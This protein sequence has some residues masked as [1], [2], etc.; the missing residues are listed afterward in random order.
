[1]NTNSHA[2]EIVY[3]GFGQDKPP[4]VINEESGLEI[5]LVRAAFATQNTEV[6]IRLFPRKML[7]QQVKKRLDGASALTQKENDGLFYSVPYLVFFNVLVTKVD[8]KITANHVADLAGLHVSGWQGASHL[9]GSELQSLIH[10]SQGALAD[11]HEVNAQ[12]QQI[13]MLLTNRTDALIIDRNIFRWYWLKLP[14]EDRFDYSIHQIFPKTSVY[15]A[16]FRME[17][18]RD[19]FN[20][21]LIAIKNNGKYDAIWQSYFNEESIPKQQTHNDG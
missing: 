7:Y 16:A 10:Q 12:A 11:Y 20:A 18:L 21:G 8:R 2:F 1:M 6:V 15:Q 13:S 19:Q 9:L 14:E 4:Y 17:K 5:D 3:I